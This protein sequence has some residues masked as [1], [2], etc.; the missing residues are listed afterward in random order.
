MIELNTIL[1]SRFENLSKNIIVMFFTVS[2]NDH[3][4]KYAMNSTNMT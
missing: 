3:V 1:A 2:C 4:I